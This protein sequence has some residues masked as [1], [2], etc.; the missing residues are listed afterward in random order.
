MLA[1]KEAQFESAIAEARSKADWEILQLRH[2]L[3][4]ADINYANNIDAMNERFEMEKGKT[5]LRWFCIFNF[6]KLI[7]F[8]CLRWAA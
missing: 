8:R 6:F 4:K 1:S 5:R 3:D 2:L 7:R